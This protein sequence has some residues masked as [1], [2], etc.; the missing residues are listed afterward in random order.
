MSL[1]DPV[2][3]QS[4]LISSI[5]LKSLYFRESGFNISSK[6]NFYAIISAIS[7]PVSPPLGLKLKLIYLL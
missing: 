5:F 3:P 1:K 4:N 2:V 6:N 7:W